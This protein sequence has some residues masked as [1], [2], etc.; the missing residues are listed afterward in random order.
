MG[1]S[2]RLDINS[3]T[4]FE[5]YRL[6]TLES[7]HHQM[8]SRMQKSHKKI[9]KLHLIAALAGSL[10]I[11]KAYADTGSALAP[12]QKY[13]MP[14]LYTGL[15]LGVQRLTGRRSEITQA[16]S[17]RLVPLEETVIFSD[18]LRFSNNNGYYSA[19]V[20]FTW[21]VP[22]IPLFFGPEIYL[23][24]GSATT[25]LKQTVFEVDNNLKRTLSASISQSWFWGGSL[26]I[27]VDYQKKLRPYLLFGIDKS[28]F[29]YT[30]TYIPRSEAA[31]DL[32][33]GNPEVLD[34]PNTLLK[35]RK[36]LRAFF[37]GVGI[38]KQFNNWRIGADVRMM[39][40]KELKSAYKAITVDP[41]TLF[42][43]FKPNNIRFGLKASY[44]F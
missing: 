41:E 16:T 32:I 23:G 20:G 25:D 38:E 28:A 35:T 9:R 33:L 21:D 22:N 39:R 40:Y 2:N 6:P 24:R 11:S 3:M 14:Q 17:D 13:Y 30:G 1:Y 19:H 37:W 42:S 15:S 44:L 12:S 27:G 29:E 18:R 31:I 5:A 43:S 8:L 34:L 4:F 10:G 7:T 26:Q 36:W